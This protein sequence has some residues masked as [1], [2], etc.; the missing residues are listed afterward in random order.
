[1][2]RSELSTPPRSAQDEALIGVF[3]QLLARSSWIE[4]SLQA[5][6]AA[7]GVHLSRPQL[8]VMT[9][10]TP[11]G[12][13]GAELARRIG[14]SRQAMQR[15]TRELEALGLVV[16]RPAPWGRTVRLVTP[17]DDGCAI[18]GRLDA[19]A[20]RLRGHLGRQT[21]PGS[22]DALLELMRT[23]WGPAV[24]APRR[25]RRRPREG[26]DLAAHPRG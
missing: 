19:A 21:S 15:T 10:L 4:Q 22:L 8:R 2:D 25:P 23:P 26:H 1:M 24:T 7:D 9:A 6:L 20:A 5:L 12:E 13:P 16:L 18:L 17:T 14:V 3:V 11:A